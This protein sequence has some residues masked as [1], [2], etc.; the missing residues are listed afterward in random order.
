MKLGGGSWFDP[1]VSQE[2]KVDMEPN[3]EILGWGGFL[4]ET[5]ELPVL[6]SK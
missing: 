6:G 2:N 5:V 3:L 4:M 1:G